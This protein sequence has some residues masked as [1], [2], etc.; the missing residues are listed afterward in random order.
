MNKWEAK[1]HTLCLGITNQEV[2]KNSELLVESAIKLSCASNED[3][4]S[5][6]NSM[7]M[8]ANHY[9]SVC[10]GKAFSKGEM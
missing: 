1:Y 4:N 5:V 3:L 8:A 9:N 6:V 10:Y 7:L 2:I